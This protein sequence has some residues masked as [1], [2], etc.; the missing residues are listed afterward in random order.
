MIKR[1]IPLFVVL[2]LLLSVSVSAVDVTEQGSDQSE[3]EASDLVFEEGSV[4]STEILP[5]I[6]GEY[7]VAPLAS[8]SA[9]VT[10][11]TMTETDWLSSI[12]NVLY[13]PESSDGVSYSIYGLL[14][15]VWSNSYS[16]NNWLKNINQNITAGTSVLNTISGYL[17][18][19]P[20]A[21]GVGDVLLHADGSVWAHPETTGLDWILSQ[22]LVGLT[23]HMDNG[24][25][26]ISGYLSSNPNSDG[27][28][29]VILRAS[30]KYESI[31]DVCGLDW[32]LSQ[33]LVGLTVHLDDGFS[34]LTSLISGSETD[35][36]Y[37]GSITSNDNAADGFSS[38]GLGPMLNTWLGAIEQN[39]GQL[40]YM[41]ADDDQLAE[42]A[43]EKEEA[44][45]TKN[46]IA[47]KTDEMDTL[48]EDMN[49]VNK[50]D[51]D[52]VVPDVNIVVS[53]NDISVI[54][55]SLAP[56]FQQSL[57]LNYLLIVCM[58]MF[59][60]YVLFGKKG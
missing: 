22:G 20:T 14:M 30:G 10:Y 40:A 4:V 7:S 13:Q 8:T 37:S 48:V 51:V 33:G 26:T 56:W 58:L 53:D 1:I 11:S 54:S 9:A 32:I 60:S 21:N 35:N 12:Y 5:V 43:Q 45:Q 44:E 6:D 3:V 59:V 24:F 28:G 15:Q 47:E 42:K 39:L 46:E 57:F 34:G 49:S 19:N 29:D 41:Y 18:S 31:A 17:S 2:A 52:S 38:V 25:S 23:V 50:P 27:V 36:T 16:A 55:D